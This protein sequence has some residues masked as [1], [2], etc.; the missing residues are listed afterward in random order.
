LVT[1][2]GTVDSVTITGDA[3]PGTAAREVPFNE[4]SYFRAALSVP[5]CGVSFFLLTDPQYATYQSSGRLPPSTFDCNQ[6]L[7]FIRAPIGHMVTVSNAKPGVANQS[8]E[9]TV[10]FFGEQ[11]PYA[12]LSIPGALLGLGATISIAGTMLSRGAAKLSEDYTQLKKRK[13]K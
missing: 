5:S 10:E 12:I 3:P 4:T 2:L 13:R 11:H 6:T 7:A 1:V 8:Y 9:I